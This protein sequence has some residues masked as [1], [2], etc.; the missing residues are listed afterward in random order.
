MSRTIA[1]S[2]RFSIAD[3]T[4]QL[5]LFT[6]GASHQIQRGDRRLDVLAEAVSDN[7]L[8]LRIG[9]RSAAVYFAEASGKKYISLGGRQYVVERVL[10]S[11]AE[12]GSVQTQAAEMERALVSPMP[13]QVVKML[14][15]EGDRVEKDQTVAIVE[16]MKMENEL[17]AP[18]RARVRKVFAAAGD[19]VDAGQVIVEL[20]GE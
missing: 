13:G 4:H 14:V 19:L 10:R 17:R 7:C 15:S 2:Y 12:G 18:A 1:K 20:E 8:L 11:A 5:T 16:A 9:G 6:E 3:T